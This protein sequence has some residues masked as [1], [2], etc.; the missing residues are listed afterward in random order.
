MKEQI[1]I[2]TMKLKMHFHRQYLHRGVVPYHYVKV[3]NF[4]LNNNGKIDKGKLP[5]SK[6]TEVTKTNNHVEN[7]IISAYNTISR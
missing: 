3:D 4:V 1:I 2:L 6:V 7:V 5:K